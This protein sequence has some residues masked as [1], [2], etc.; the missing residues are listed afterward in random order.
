MDRAEAPQA[1]TGLVICVI[2]RGDLQLRS[3]HKSGLKQQARPVDW[4]TGILA[5]PMHQAC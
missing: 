3:E 2:P 4:A 5:L 1:K